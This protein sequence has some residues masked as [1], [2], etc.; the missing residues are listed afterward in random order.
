[1]APLKQRYRQGS[2][3]DTIP[4]G[5]QREC[6]WFAA[7]GNM[8]H[9]SP[10]KTTEYREIFQAFVAAQ[11]HHRVDG[12]LK[13]YREIAADIGGARGYMSTPERRCIGGPE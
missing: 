10:L 13:S 12:S 3:T 1:M 5:C 2:E 9:A 4:N 6:E 8:E 11:K 7:N